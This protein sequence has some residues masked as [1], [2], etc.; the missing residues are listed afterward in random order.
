MNIESD[1]RKNYF[2]QD[3]LGKTLLSHAIEVN[4][5]DLVTL[6]IEHG[7]HVGQI[8]VR[9]NEEVGELQGYRG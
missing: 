9:E 5:L 8:R 4:N 7:A 6:L 3:R 2:L 1:C